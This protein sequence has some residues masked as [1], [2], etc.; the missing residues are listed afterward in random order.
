[1]KLNNL[2]AIAIFALFPT[3]VAARCRVNIAVAGPRSDVRNFHMYTYNYYDNVCWV[4]GS[5]R[6]RPEPDT[7]Y[8]L[9]CRSG[10]HS[11]GCQFYARLNTYVVSSIELGNC[12]LPVLK[13]GGYYAI[14]ATTGTLHHGWPN[15]GRAGRSSKSSFR[16]RSKSS[17]SSKSSKASKSRRD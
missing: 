16:G 10:R 3:L 17:K 13:C 4:S 14:D 8:T 9:S 2:I 7:W 6:S 5:S 1:M 15:S 12:G 11:N